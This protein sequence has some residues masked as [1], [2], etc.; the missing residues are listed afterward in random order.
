[1]PPRPRRLALADRAVASLASGHPWV[2]RDSVASLPPGLEPGDLVALVD[3]RGAALG[4]ALADPTSPIVARVLTSDEGERPDG[5]WLARKLAAAFALRRSI[6]EPGDTDA[7]RLVYGEGDGLPG[8]VIDRYGD[9]AVLRTDGAAAEAWL[10]RERE[11]VWGALR[12]EGVRSA[13]LRDTAKGVEGPKARPWAGDEPPASLAV[14]EHGMTMEVDLL[15]GQ[16]TGAFLDQ[17]DNRRVVRSL[18][19]R[20]RVLNLFS[21]AGGFS[22]AAKLGGAERVTSVDRAAGG[23]AS[24]QRSY[25]LNGLDPG[26]DAFV[27]ADAFAFLEAAAARGERWGLVVCDPP[28][29]APNERSKAR[30]LGAYRALHTACAKVL[31]PGG[32]FCAASCSSHVGP[33]EFLQTLDARAL[34]PGF[35]LCELR[36][37]PPDHPTTPAWREGRYLKFA[38]LA[39]PPDARPPRLRQP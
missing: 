2:Y 35:R 3:G 28:S 31:E 14:R 37:L 24:A 8:L 6:V 22:L 17:R 18:A 5:A 38:I 1:M 39:G 12:A 10:E 34:G 26:G 20:K 23:H 11:A 30:A 7:Y 15:R 13:A 21:Y 16:K 9:V 19:A 36:G 25:R 32:L 29:F 33:D 4:Y 27:T